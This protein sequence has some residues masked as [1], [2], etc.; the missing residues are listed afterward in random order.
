M[1]T[2]KKKTF[3]KLVNA[4]D[5]LDYPSS[6]DG[7][8]LND[9]VEK[10]LKN[11]GAVLSGSRYFANRYKEEVVVQKLEGEEVEK[12]SIF[13]D[14]LLNNV[15]DSDW[16]YVIQDSPETR[17]LLSDH[18]F[19]INAP[20]TEYLDD[21]TTG[22]L[23]HPNY[24]DPTSFSSVWDVSDGQEQ[25]DELFNGISSGKVD[26]ILKKDLD[27]YVAMME[28]LSVEF[29]ARCVWKRSITYE[30]NNLGEFMTDDEVRSQ[31]RIII[32]DLYKMVKVNYD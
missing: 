4:N 30:R 26:I 22:L 7:D 11:I 8:H 23:S 31:I 1:A 14:K 10:I 13:V 16:D 3:K 12:P 24:L 29:Y 15:K 32:N 25:S 28:N 27:L 19:Y 17:Q 20:P 18:G 6:F 9:S 5:N 21:N 2:L